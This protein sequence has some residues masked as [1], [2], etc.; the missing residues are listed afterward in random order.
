MA[1]P[2]RGSDESASDSWSHVRGRGATATQRLVVLVL[3]WSGLSL[4]QFWLYKVVRR[5]PHCG[6]LP[7]LQRN[8]VLT[9]GTRC[10]NLTPVD[11]YPSGTSL[12]LPR[13]CCH[14]TPEVTQEERLQTMTCLGASVKT[15]AADTRE[16]E[17]SGFCSAFCYLLGQNEGVHVSQLKQLLHICFTN[18]T[19][20]LASLPACQQGPVSM[21][22]KTLS[23]FSSQ[24][25]LTIFFRTYKDFSL[26]FFF[27]AV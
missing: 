9:G 27:S 16:A 20:H 24:Q 1:T 7:R 8:P 13:F 22:V 12:C 14:R 15:K 17:R 23:L 10:C 6:H 2:A 26:S 3:T 19:I 25:K 21:S 4:S 5:N 18:T 11:N